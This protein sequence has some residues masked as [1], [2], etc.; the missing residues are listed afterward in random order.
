M[1]VR[2]GVKVGGV[3]ELVTLPNNYVVQD[4]TSLARCSH[5]LY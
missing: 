1:D 3:K 4:V 2:G 5:P